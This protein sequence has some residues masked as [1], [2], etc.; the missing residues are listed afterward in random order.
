MKCCSV[1]KKNFEFYKG[2]EI[3]VWIEGTIEEYALSFLHIF[4]NV[5]DNDELVRVTNDYGSNV[6]VVCY[7]DALDQTKKYLEQFGKITDVSSALIAVCG[8][9]IEYDYSKYDVIACDFQ[10]L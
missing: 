8:D 9:D 4:N 1:A 5:K 7:A 10:A 2:F 3:S 6:S